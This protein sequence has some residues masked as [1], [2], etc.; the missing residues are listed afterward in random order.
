MVPKW[1]LRKS[2]PIHSKLYLQ[3]ALVSILSNKTPIWRHVYWLW[4]IKATV[5][6]SLTSHRTHI[7]ILL[8]MKSYIQNMNVNKYLSNEI[9]ILYI[10][11]NREMT[12]WFWKQTTRDF[13]SNRCSFCL[14]LGKHCNMPFELS[15]LP[16]NEMLRVK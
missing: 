13:Q 12:E 7:K 1:P 5:C 6:L 3:W 15:P 9:I 14:C 16:W 8:Q 11:I 2:M 4:F 10:I